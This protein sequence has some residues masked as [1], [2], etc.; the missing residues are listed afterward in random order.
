[1]NLPVIYAGGCYGGYLAHLI[2]KIAPHH[3]NAVIDI[4]CA[5]LPFF[6]MFMGRALGHGECFV[7]TNEFIFHCFTKTFWNESNFT[8]A[9]Y[10]IRSLLTSSHL[11]VQK[12]NCKHIHFV[13]YHSSEDE[14]ETAKD[15]KLLYEIYKNMG[16]DAALHLIKKDDIDNKII[17]NLTHGGI[18]NHRVFLKELPLLLE[19]FEGQ[20]FPLLNASISYPCEDKIFTFEDEK[21]GFKLKL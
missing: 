1:G 17:R 12:D 15:K 20:N 5:P 10:E 3:T 13:S 14:F 4:A 8:K 2:A 6:E 21:E 18:S 19:K 9:H 7:V 16:F 11:E